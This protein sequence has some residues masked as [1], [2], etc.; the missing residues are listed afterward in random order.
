MSQP[1]EEVK[2]ATTAQVGDDELRVLRRGQG[3]P[4]LVLHDELGYPGWMT[5]NQTLSDLR[6]L[7]I[8]LQP[9]FGD[10]PRVEWV[11]DFRDLAS[12]YARW[13]RESVGTPIDA[14][15]FSAGG[16]LAAEIAAADP[17]LFR[18][19]ILVAPLGVKPDPGE[20]LDFFALTLRTHVAAT[21]ARHEAPEFGEIY[22]GEMTP[23]QFERFEDARAESARIGW[24]PFM[25]S[26]SLPKRLEA[27][28]GLPVLLVWGDGDLVT[29]RGCVS[30]YADALPDAQ[31]A[32]LPGV[33][34]RP[35][36]EDPDT[37]LEIVT[38]FLGL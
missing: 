10:T 36:I 17:D 6:E 24:E 13:L 3:E 26:P 23:V 14:V 12:L 22:G 2:N 29:P 7:W 1:A 33:G 4:L 16:Y 20:I 34:H 9:G 21:V 11:M 38:K 15:A 8:P 30:G 31:V 37:F 25:H 5:W 27:V 32:E 18:R 19:L 35:E 28:Q